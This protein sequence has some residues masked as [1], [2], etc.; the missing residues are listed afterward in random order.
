M[1]ARIKPE[2]NNLNGKTVFAVT[3]KNGIVARFNTKSEAR[4]WATQNGYALRYS[5]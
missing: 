1:D 4:D 2:T 3:T 5:G